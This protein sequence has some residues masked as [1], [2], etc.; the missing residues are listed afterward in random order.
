MET[1]FS[2]S[3]QNAFTSSEGFS[4][5]PGEG[6]GPLLPLAAVC[7]SFQLRTVHSFDRCSDTLCPSQSPEAHAV[8][9]PAEPLKV[10]G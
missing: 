9:A 7:P 6:A 2:G 1:C 10:P 4:L 5:L 8:A 3:E